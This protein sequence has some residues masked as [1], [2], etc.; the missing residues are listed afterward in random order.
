MSDTNLFVYDDNSQWGSALSAHLVD[1]VPANIIDALR[2]NSSRYVEDAASILFSGVGSEKKRLI[3]VVESWIESQSVAAYHGSRLDA[4]DL[5]SVEA[6]GLRRMVLA[7]RPRQL[8]KKLSGH[9]RWE[10]VKMSL[11]QVLREQCNKYQIG[12]REGQ[13]HATLSR[14]GLIYAFNHYL[15][16]G[17]EFDQHAAFQLL[18]SEGTELLTKYGRPI[19]ITLAV[20]G[21]NALEAAN[22]FREIGDECPNIVR[23]VLQIWS[24]CL[25][26]QIFLRAHCEQT[27][28][29]SFAMTFRQNGF[30]E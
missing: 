29:C 27:V 15:T 10:M 11:E 9:A 25:G 20:P 2:A 18:G 5:K 19:L 23:E 17:S 3:Q 13:A 22:P 7:E 8:E 26:I 30:P 14:A 12:G 21:G 1:V 24:Y 4:E 28:V 6:N 16:R